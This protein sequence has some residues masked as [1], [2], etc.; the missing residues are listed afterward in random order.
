MHNKLLMY[1]N[2]P[3]ESGSGRVDVF[4]TTRSGPGDDTAR[5]RIIALHA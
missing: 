2:N 1:G 3:S 4:E 5:R